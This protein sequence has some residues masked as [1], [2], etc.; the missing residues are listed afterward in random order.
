M[1]ETRK[2][3]TPRAMNSSA[4]KRWQREERILAGVLLGWGVLNVID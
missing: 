3:S 2:R 1:R 4:K